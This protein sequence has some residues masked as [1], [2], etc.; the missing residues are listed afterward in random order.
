MANPPIL[1]LKNFKYENQTVNQLKWWMGKA[2]ESEK[3]KAKAWIIVCEWL[4]QAI[5]WDKTMNYGPRA[6]EPL[7]KL[8]ASLKK[9]VDSLISNKILENGKNLVNDIVNLI[10]NAENETLKRLARNRSTQDSRDLVKKSAEV[11][12][13]KTP[14]FTMEWGDDIHKQTWN[15]VFTK[16]SNPVKIHRALEWLFKTPNTTYTIDYSQCKNQNIKSWMHS[17]LWWY[18]CLLTYDSKLKTYVLRDTEWQPLQVRARIREWVKLIPA[19]ERKWRAYVQEKKEK[20]NLGSE[21]VYNA[22]KL[23]KLTLSMQKAIPSA[24]KELTTREQ[25][26]LCQKTE[27]RIIELLKNAKKLW[28]EIDPES[29]TKIFRWSWH[30]EL[31][32]N[33]GDSEVSWTVRKND[34]F[35]WKKLYDFI[36]N[37]EWDYKDYLISRVK[38]K[39]QELDPL[40]KTEKVKVWADSKE[41]IIG[42]EAKQQILYGMWLLET[43]IE[44]YRESEWDSWL[45]NDD[46][47]LVE[48]KK[49]LRNGRASIEDTDNIWRSGIIKNII[50]PIRTKRKSIKRISAKGDQ[51][52]QLNNVFFWNKDQQIA[53]IRSLWW[54]GRLFDKTETSFL[55]EEIEW[56]EDIWVKNPEIQKC[57]DKIKNRTSMSIYNQDWSINQKVKWRYDNTYASAQKWTDSLITLFVGRWWLPSN[58]KEE[59][60]EVRKCMD[61]LREQLVSIDTQVNNLSLSVE[62]EMAKG[63]KERL[64]L[65]QKDNKTEAE[66]QVLQALVYWDENPEKA[67]EYYKKTI[68][69]TNIQLKYGD[70]WQ[71]VKWWLMSALGELWWWITWKNADI[72]NDIK[73]Y[74]FW[75]LSDE[76]AKIAWEILAEIVIMVVV[77]VCTAWVWT[78]AVAW[79]LRGVSLIARSARWVKLANNISKSVR[80]LKVFKAAKTFKQVKR[81]FKVASTAGKV[82]LWTSIPTALLIEGTG[83]NAAKT[84]VD[85][86]VKG[87]SLDN[88]NLNPI[89]KENVQTAAFLGALSIAGKLT[90][91][92]M[93]VWWKS[94]LSVNLMEWLKKRHIQ[95]PARCTTQLVTEMWSMLAAE[96]VINLTFWHDVI[97]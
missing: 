65:E 31:H 97:V 35:I 4:I 41:I 22:D 56:N 25:V 26:D 37:N 62:W 86:A 85:A 33:A 55:A 95:D 58:R 78:L 68:E 23:S 96:Q 16:E 40:T 83:F 79:A 81:V 52:T 34:S 39:L 32:L 57:I 5:K 61:G 19:W 89:A 43:M 20:E 87:T 46:K 60:D 63:H 15:I 77:G 51:Y 53:A 88:L 7:R 50:E 59:D 54:F 27:Q 10:D 30:M 24:K 90:Q 36:D 76:S 91:S 13:T 72:Y 94:K 42:W 74:W 73:W 93:R 82:A 12:K 2:L 80:L 11:S 47:N 48:I 17:V 38:E 18:T 44:N 70:L 92:L 49:L 28:Y 66:M 3:D 29:V 6:L 1:S 67:R 71:I 21:T 75:N 9:G 64:R 84:T 69:A 45:D 14:M 8:Q